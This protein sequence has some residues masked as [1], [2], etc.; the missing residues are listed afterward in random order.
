MS[1]LP[2]H[3]KFVITEDGRKVF[4]HGPEY[5]CLM[6]DLRDGKI[7][8]VIFDLS[9]IEDEGKQ[10]IQNRFLKAVQEQIEKL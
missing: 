2:P 9:G 7:H 8:K 3:L 4:G 1:L 10:E 5:Y 6:A